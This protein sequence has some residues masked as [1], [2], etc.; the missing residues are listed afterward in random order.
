MEMARI[1][2]GEVGTRVTSPLGPFRLADIKPGKLR[3]H[4]AEIVEGLVERLGGEPDRLFLVGGSW[5]AIARLDMIRRDYP[6]AVLH[7]YRMSPESVAET[8]RWIEASD[9]EDLRHRAGL[10]E[11]RMALVPLAA[12]V[13]REVVAGF[14]PGE[15]AISSYGIREG[16]LYEQMPEDLRARDPL[17]EACRFAESKDARLP[18]FGQRLFRFVLPLFKDAPERE[19]RIVHAACLLHDVSWRAHPDYRHEVCFD[20]ATRANLG[21]LTHEERVFLGLS[22]LHRYKGSRDGLFDDVVALL[23]EGMEK[24]A[25]VLGRAMR[26]GAMF[27]VKDPSEVGE[28][29]WFPAKKRLEIHV[30]PPAEALFGEVAQS[31]FQALAGAMGAESEVVR[32]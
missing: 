1:G 3:A 20:N 29:R 15:I 6:L 19:Q 28:L 18:G 26:L 27:T 12:K 10:S 17:I 7:E 32:R 24:R 31:R 30:L 23:P 9:I 2:D 16:L 4:I 8:V 25:E 14:Q 13:L 22:L 5:R 21:G 11:A